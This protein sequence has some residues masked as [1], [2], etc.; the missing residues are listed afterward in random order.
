MCALTKEYDESECDTIHTFII[1]PKQWNLHWHSPLLG[2]MQ[3]IPHISEV[4]LSTSHSHTAIYTSPLLISSELPF[5]CN[6][7]TVLAHPEYGPVAFSF[8]RV[9]ANH[10]TRRI[11]VL[12]GY[13]KT[14]EF[15]FCKLLVERLERFL[16]TI[17][18]HAEV[19]IQPRG[20]LHQNYF[21]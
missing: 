10:P 17:A 9:L 2:C 3:H 4:S 15:K 5:R 11:I 19:Q 18:P 12:D 8:Y 20:D 21:S 6:H 14:H 7:D 1:L 13:D 16:K